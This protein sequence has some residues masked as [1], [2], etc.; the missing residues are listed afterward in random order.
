[1]RK[2]LP[3]LLLVAS[4]LQSMLATGQATDCAS[5][6]ANGDCTFYTECVEGRIPCGSSGYA[7][8]YGN[9]FCNAFGEL[10]DSFNAEVRLRVWS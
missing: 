9:H 3:L 10:S 4:I 6:A 7:L 2:L 8:A 5:L 1:M